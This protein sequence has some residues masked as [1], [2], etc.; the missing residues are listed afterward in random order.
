MTISVD[1]TMGSFL[2][3]MQP[4]NVKNSMTEECFAAHLEKQMASAGNSTISL[5]A[6]QNEESI[7]GDIAI[8][9]EKGL[10]TYIMEIRAQRIREEILE[11]M[12]LTEE[13]LGKL[14]PE[15]Q[16]AVEKAIAEEI[17]KRMEAESMS[18]EDYDKISNKY[19]LQEIETGIGSLFLSEMAEMENSTIAT[20]GQGEEKE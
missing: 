7:G 1:Y 14:P 11:S 15:Q 2:G 12:G 13:E 18:Q 16:A 10:V 8:I 20:V 3:S 19:K 17:Q 4:Y 9:K 6:E 5:E